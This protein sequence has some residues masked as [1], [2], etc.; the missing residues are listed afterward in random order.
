MS[1][2]VKTAVQ[3]DREFVHAVAEQVFSVYD[4]R[5][6]DWSLDAVSNPPS[7][8]A[9]ATSVWK[10][11]LA[12]RA[13]VMGVELAS[14]RVCVKLFYDRSRKGRLRN[15]LRCSKAKRAWRCGGAMMA[16]HVPV[17][18][19]IGYAEDESGMGMV[20]AEL[21]EDALRLDEWIKQ[22]G[23]GKSAAL[24]LGRVIRKMHDA[25]VTH[26]DL[27]VRNIL[28]RDDAHDF[29]LLDY[30]DARFSKHVSRRQRL[31]N[32]HHLNERALA[33][34]P[35]DVRRAFLTAYLNDGNE[36]STEQWCRA[37]KR[38][39]ERHPSKYTAAHFE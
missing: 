15:R 32:L 23:A 33:T 22:N 36:K 4:G 9:A 25:G 18:A 7:F 21:V 2:A 31:N 16:R 17:P 38:M 35:E 37:L 24:A 11:H 28:V 27:S 30:E 26:R 20:I 12:D 5:G 29:V 14:R 34:V 19:M 8:D 3:E 13:G 39:M 1:V 10:I 6:R